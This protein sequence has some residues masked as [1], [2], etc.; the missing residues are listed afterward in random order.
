VQGLPT[1][2]VLQGAQ[3]LLDV[4]TF[5]LH[6]DGGIAKCRPELKINNCFLMLN[7]AWIKSLQQAGAEL[8]PILVR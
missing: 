4:V 6:S 2:K 5:S 3:V 7:A 1:S 8:K